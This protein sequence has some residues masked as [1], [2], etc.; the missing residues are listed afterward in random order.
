MLSAISN[1]GTRDAKKQSKNKTKNKKM[2]P[3]PMEEEIFLSISLFID[4]QKYSS[5]D[6]IKNPLNF[7]RI[8]HKMTMK[9]M[10]YYIVSI[11]TI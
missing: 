2:L 3:L 11:K 10:K 8:F 7:G 9:F 4:P 5:A 6:M 1:P